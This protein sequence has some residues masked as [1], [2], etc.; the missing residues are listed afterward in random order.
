MN[1]T[2]IVVHHSGGLG[3]NN[4]ASTAHLTTAH[5]EA[6]HKRKWSFLSDLGYYSGYNTIYD[7]KARAFYERRAVGEETAAQRGHNFDTFSICIIGNFNQRGWTRT[8]VDPMTKQ[9]EQ[10]V[11]MYLR[12]LIDGNKRRLIVSG[13]SKL[14]FSIARVYAHRFFSAT[15]CYGT[16]LSG[17]WMRDLLVKYDR[18]ELGEEGKRA[19]LKE[20]LALVQM[21]LKLYIKLNDLLTATRKKQKAV[22]AIGDRECDGLIIN[23]YQAKK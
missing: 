20:K 12:D 7:P 17:N 13:N 23:S 4:Q 21:I 11:S 15:S 2:N 22:G 18:V 9:I 8:S 10:D 1:I 6:H 5:I 14:R 16:F 3:T 19:E